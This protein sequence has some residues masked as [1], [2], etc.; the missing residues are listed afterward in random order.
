MVF[1]EKYKRLKNKEDIKKDSIELEIRDKKQKFFLDSI[2]N[3]NQISENYYNLYLLPIT[4]KYKLN[5]TN[6]LNLLK[7]EYNLSIPSNTSL[8][9][10]SFEKINKPNLLKTSNGRII[11][12]LT[13]FNKALN[14][15]DISEQNRIFLMFT[16][17]DNIALN[18]SR[19]QFIKCF[20]I[21]TKITK[22]VEVIDYFKRLA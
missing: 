18:Y 16:Y 19:E 1:F 8:V 7:K 6:P 15:T 9:K 21:F 20:T 17:L 11:D 13:L 12:Y 14:K 2:R 3:I 5:N 22:R 10:K 4:N